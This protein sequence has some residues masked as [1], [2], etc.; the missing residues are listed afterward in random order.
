MHIGEATI[1]AVVTEGQLFVVDAEQVEHRC[2]QIV[3]VRGIC[4]CLVRPLVAFAIGCAAFDASA[5]QPGG[6]GVGV[7]VAA[8]AALT[9]GHAA[10][11]GGPDDDGVVQESP[12]LQVLE[13]CRCGSVHAC[14]HIPMIPRQVFV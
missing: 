9:A 14:A 1:D 2:M 6:E 13:Q 5:C 8:L 11:L 10:E 12:G 3:A 4:R 7:V